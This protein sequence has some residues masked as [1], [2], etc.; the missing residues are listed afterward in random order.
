MP[1]IQEVIHKFEVGEGTRVIQSLV[2]IL[3]LIALTAWYDLHQ[4]Q[5]F[6]TP[7]AMESAQLARNLAAGEGFTTKSIR[8]LSLYLVEQHQGVGA[9]LSRQPH[10]DLA[11]PPLYPL[12]LAVLLKVVPL[13]YGIDASFWR[14]PPELLIAL[15]NQ[16]LFFLALWLT[17]R[18]ARRLFDLPVAVLATV[19][20]A[21]SDVL[22]RFSVSGQSTLLL[23]L[24][25]V[26][27]LWC[28]VR[29][30]EA[31]QAQEPPEDDDAGVSAP[32]GPPA[33]SMGR[34]RFVGWGVAAGWLVG[35]GALT[36]YSFGWLLIPVLVFCVA[37]LGRRR[38]LVAGLVLG[39]FLLTL[40]PWC[41]R[42]YTLSGTLFGVQGFALQQQSTAF[43][44]TRLER[45]LRPDLRQVELKDY[46][47]KL[48]ANLGELMRE[49]FPKL[50][51]SWLGAFFLAGLLLPYRRPTLRRLRV[52][53][54]LSLVT[55]GVAQALG[56][57]HL[58][59][60]SP[61]ISSENLLVLLT[62][63]VLVLGVG[64]YYVL[65][66]QMKLPFPELRHLVTV[67]VAMVGCAQLLLT[68]LPPR[69]YPI[70]YPPYLPTWIQL[71]SRML[72]TNELMMSDMPWAVAWYGNRSCVWTPLNTSNAFYEIYDQQKPV[73][74]VYLT[75]LSTDA[76]LLTQVAQG[77]DWDWSRFALNTMML[78]N[79]PANFPL[80]HA[81]RALMPDQLLLFDRPRWQEPLPAP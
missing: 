66:D 50:G 39:A 26:G 16:G 29:L 48:C 35:L 59:V 14:Y 75:P 79:L 76:R 6:H 81:W 57:T 43:P 47:R 74:G 25:L 49:D 55:L 28:L 36:R 62:P 61:T 13:N 31:A 69:V 30:S 72:K 27:L 32:P 73:A 53:A 52:F 45:S 23:V 21:G 68:L 17:F 67:V 41:V 38:A 18:L 5:N 80:Q 3:L 2:G 58:G 15:F 4:F 7:E 54:L 37:Y 34:W 8:P 56:R 11:T 33:G 22:W 10:P 70:V 51:G 1:P 9:R 12:L 42:N 24:I 77:P 44:E 78:T 46:G 20:M 60:Q 19:L 40:G 63:L 64:C 71:V 65:L